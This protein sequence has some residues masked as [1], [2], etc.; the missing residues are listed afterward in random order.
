[1]QVMPLQAKNPTGMILKSATTKP[2]PEL[3]HD[4]EIGIEKNKAML[5]MALIFIT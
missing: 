2:K 4:L 1:M 5:A 3:L